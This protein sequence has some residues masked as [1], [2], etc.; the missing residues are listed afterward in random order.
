MS[1]S[2]C[3]PP[4]S[5]LLLL[6][7]DDDVAAATVRLTSGTVVQV[8]GESL[9]VRHDVPIGHKVAVRDLAA[10]STVH[11]YGASIGSAS[12]PIRAGDWVHVH[13]LQSDYL[14]TFARGGAEAADDLVEET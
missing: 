10:G 2:S 8:G 9:I 14:P 6:H 1:E 11:K 4:E 3:V 5:C 12:R 13:N 7:P